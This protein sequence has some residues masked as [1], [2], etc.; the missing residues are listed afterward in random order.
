MKKTAG[1]TLGPLT[2]TIFHACAELAGALLSP[3]R[4]KALGL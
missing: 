3:S 2:T 4:F 1:F